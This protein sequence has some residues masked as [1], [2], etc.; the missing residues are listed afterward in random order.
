MFFLTSDLDS[1]A[2][3]DSLRSLIELYSDD[4]DEEIFEEWEQWHSLVKQLASEPS[5]QALPTSLQILTIMNM[6]H[7]QTAF[8]NVSIALR[9]YL[10]LHPSQTAAVKGLFTFKKDKKGLYVL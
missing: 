5:S 10:I 9:I 2:V 3:K 6:H 4:L 7:L 1:T 8:P